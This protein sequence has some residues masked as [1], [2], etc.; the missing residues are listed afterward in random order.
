[1]TK[2]DPILK[3]KKRIIIIGVII[4]GFLFSPQGIEMYDEYADQM[5]NPGYL[6]LGSPEYCGGWYEFSVSADWPGTK[7]IVNFHTSVHDFNETYYP[8]SDQWGEGFSSAEYW[9]VRKQIGPD[10]YERVII[11]MWWF[12]PRFEIVNE[13]YWNGTDYVE[14]GN[15][16]LEFT[17]LELVVYDSWLSEPEYYDPVSNLTLYFDWHGWI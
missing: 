4:L 8:D 17:S 12:V 15:Q 6:G 13:A 7:V 5:V 2:K 3:R 10:V 14:T 16:Y 9:S 11:S 1:M